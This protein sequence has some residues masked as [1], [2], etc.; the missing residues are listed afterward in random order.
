[1][2]ENPG[3]IFQWR[4]QERESQDGEGRSPPRWMETTTEAP[5][6]SADKRDSQW[7]RKQ[8]QPC[9]KH[10][11]ANYRPTQDRNQRHNQHHSHRQAIQFPKHPYA[12]HEQNNRQHHECYW[13]LSIQGKDWIEKSFDDSV[14]DAG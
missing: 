9:R 3:V 10:P 14:S 2:P 8:H 13:N 7:R 4:G 5:S 11:F 1:M 12:W 6:S